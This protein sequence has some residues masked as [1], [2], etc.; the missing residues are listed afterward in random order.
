VGEEEEEEEEE[1][2]AGGWRMD[3]PTVG[4]LERTVPRRVS[5]GTH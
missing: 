1:G 5:R 2:G 4:R 3:R